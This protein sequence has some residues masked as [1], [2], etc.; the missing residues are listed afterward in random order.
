MNSKSPKIYT[1]LWRIKDHAALQTI[2]N[3]APREIVLSC[4]PTVKQQQKHQPN[5]KRN[6]NGRK[7][8]MIFFSS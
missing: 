5:T 6:L 2:A 3:A 7:Q 8:Q 4:I 1:L